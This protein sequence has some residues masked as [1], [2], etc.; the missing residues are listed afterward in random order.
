MFKKQKGVTLIELMSVIAITGFAVAAT[1]PVYNHYIEKSKMAKTMPA[2]GSLKNAIALCHLKNDT[3]ENCDSGKNGIPE[4]QMIN[5]VV[6]YTIENGILKVETKASN[7]FENIENVSFWMAPTPY[8]NAT[9][10]GMDWVVLCDDFGEESLIGTCENTIE[11]FDL[12][13]DN[14]GVPDYIEENPKPFQ[15]DLKHYISI[16]NNLHILGYDDFDS[17]QVL[18]QPYHINAIGY[19]IQ[20]GYIYGIKQGT[21]NLVKVER[22]GNYVDLGAVDGLPQSAS[23][24]FIGDFDENGNFFIIQPDKKKMFNIDVENNVVLEEKTLNSSFP[25]SDFGYSIENGKMYG[26]NNT[27]VIEF[28]LNTLESKLTPVS[29]SG[30]SGYAS[31][32]SVWIDQYENLYAYSNNSGKVFRIDDFKGQNP[33]A[34][35]VKDIG[36][37]GASDGTACIRKI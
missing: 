21:T 37:T 15:C 36:Y 6:G 14:D 20:D 1:A 34:V 2:F 12:D 27:H 24:T 5:G 35:E 4:E 11:S 30:I 19:N 16:Q 13:S 8:F 9:S 17:D 22:S 33:E 10:P 23:G 3:F 7:H 31:F 32:G 29:N 26:L 18:Q 25:A 28:D